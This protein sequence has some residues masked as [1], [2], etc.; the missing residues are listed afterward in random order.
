[1]PYLAFLGFFFFSLTVYVCG[2]WN[3]ES[4][5]LVGNVSP[6]IVARVQEK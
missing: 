2:E 5:I 6:K 3:G 4:K 1:M